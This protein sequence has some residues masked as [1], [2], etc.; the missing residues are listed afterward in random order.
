QFAGTMGRSTMF[1][2]EVVLVTA[3]ATAAAASSFAAAATA[4][5]P[6]T[7]AALVTSEHF[8]SQYLEAA[9]L[10][11]NNEVS[12]E[13]NLTEYW[14]SIEERVKRRTCEYADGECMSKKTAKRNCSGKLNK[15]AKCG[16]K[17]DV[18]CVNNDKYQK[19]ENAGGECILKKKLTKK[20]NG[21]VDKT[22]MCKNKKYVCCIS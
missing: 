15:K 20:C 17:R 10:Q 2:W 14:N 1:F 6:A 21:K 18:C 8:P 3:A 13:E 11:I 9:G 5:S 7:V 4:A 12:K 22:F 19:C 16:K